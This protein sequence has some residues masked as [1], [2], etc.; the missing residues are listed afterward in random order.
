MSEG[1]IFGEEFIPTFVM[2][3]TL[4]GDGGREEEEEEEDGMRRKGGRDRVGGAVWKNVG[5]AADR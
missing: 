2:L 3:S 4:H 1:Q 5:E